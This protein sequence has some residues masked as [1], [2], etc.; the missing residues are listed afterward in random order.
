M[1][2]AVMRAKFSGPSRSPATRSTRSATAASLTVTGYPGCDLDLGLAAVRGRGVLA[3][4]RQVDEHPA[5]DL[6]GERAHG[7]LQKGR[8]GDHVGRR[9]GPDVRDREHDRLERVEPPGDHRLQRADHR[10]GGRD[11]VER[12]VRRRGMPTTSGHGDL[13]DVAGGHDRPGP[14]QHVAGRPGRADVQGER[15][16]RRPGGL[17]HALFDHE[18]GSVVSFL[19]GLE[20]EQDPPRQLTAPRCEHPGGRGQHRDVSVVPAGVHG[21]LDLRCERQIGRL[22][23]RQ[24]VHVAAEQHGRPGRLTLEHCDDGADRLPGTHSDRQVRQGGEH[25]LLGMRQPQ[26]L[27]GIAVQRPAQRHSARLQPPG[28]REDALQPTVSAHSWPS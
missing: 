20:H 3:H 8:L 21:A 26:S 5:A 7:A 9:P 27:L 17:Q 13:Q 22:G 19:A 28:L 23:E 12:I 14:G 6:V 4:G 1:I 10:S 11:R 15:L 25:G 2:G 18:T 24:R 16:L